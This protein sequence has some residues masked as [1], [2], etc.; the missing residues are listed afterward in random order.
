MLN[1]NVSTPLSAYEAMPQ[2]LREKLL[3]EALCQLSPQVLY[4][5]EMIQFEVNPLLGSVCE[6]DVQTV[7]YYTFRLAQ[8]SFN[9]CRELSYA[10][11]VFYPDYT[12]V[13]RENSELPVYDLGAPQKGQLHQPL[14]DDMQKLLYMV[15]FD[16]V[17]PGVRRFGDK[18][19]DGLCIPRMQAMPESPGRTEALDA[20]ERMAQAAIVLCNELGMA[21]RVLLRSVPAASSPAQPVIPPPVAVGKPQP[22]IDEDHA[23]AADDD[24][25]PF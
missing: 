6:A 15:G 11:R 14:P 7:A 18:I 10:A 21:G 1:D 20:L 22:I 25:M 24:D 12:V 8:A 2:E 17:F 13:P 19:L 23:F 16:Q 5:G 4:F 3:F 9:L